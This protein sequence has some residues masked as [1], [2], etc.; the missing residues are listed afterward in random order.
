LW[1]PEIDTV[2]PDE[3]GVGVADLSGCS[4]D[5]I[6]ADDVIDEKVEE[7]EQLVMEGKKSNDG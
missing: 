5:V 6:F 7:E 4:C 1:S 3:D 2:K